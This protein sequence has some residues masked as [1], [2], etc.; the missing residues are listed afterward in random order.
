MTFAIRPRDLVRRV[1]AFNAKQEKHLLLLIR[2]YDGVNVETA[3][4]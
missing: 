3:D 4:L 2:I 1:V